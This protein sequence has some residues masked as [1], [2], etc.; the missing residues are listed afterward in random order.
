MTKYLIAIS[1]F[2]F[3]FVS[4]TPSEST[5]KEEHSE[6]NTNTS[7][8]V[9]VYIASQGSESL[10]FYSWKEGAKEPTGI[11]PRLI[12]YILHQA[13]LEFEYVT[14]YQYQGEGDPRV[15]AVAEG[16]ADVSIRGITVNEER[17][18]QVLFSDSYYTDG[19][20]IMVMQE[21]ELFKK[22]DLKEKKVFAYRFSTSYKWAEENLKESQL[23]STKDFGLEV[24]PYELLEQGKIDALLTD[25][26]ALKR[27]Q[28]KL[29]NTRLFP[30][31]FTQEEYGIAISKEHPEIKEKI[32][33]VIQEM[34]ESGRL[35]DFTSGFEK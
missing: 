8:P 14:D 3:L 35:A 22:E 16:H 4:C 2:S 21:S 17:A 23:M 5:K 13:G 15:L 7:K 9:R 19:L 30:R 28:N 12:S 11:E 26:S 20:G 1:L 10:P 27:I 29:P 32:D 34:R 33:K 6:T 31:K 18:Q 25:Y 24:A